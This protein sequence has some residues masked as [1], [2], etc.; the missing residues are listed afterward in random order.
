MDIFGGYSWR[1]NNTFK[2]MK[3]GSKYINFTLSINNLLNNTKFR[4]SGFEQLRFDFTD[5]NPNKFANKYFY[6]YGINAF[7]NVTYRM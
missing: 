5:R 6:N 3:G 7:I 4:T 2:K 1:L